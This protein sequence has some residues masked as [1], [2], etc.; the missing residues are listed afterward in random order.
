ML[1]QLA[2]GVVPDNIEL[3]LMILLP[4]P[5]TVVFVLEQLAVLGYSSR[6]VIAGS[7]LFAPALGLG[8]ARYMQNPT[9]KR[10][11][12]MVLLFGTPALAALIH[13]KLSDQGD[14]S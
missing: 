9:D 8:L 5:T 2:T 3:A 7:V 14:S 4:I 1:V 6:R 11:W 13:Q 10:F 12:G